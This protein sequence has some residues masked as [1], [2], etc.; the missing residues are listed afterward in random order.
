M[1]V[2]ASLM[3]VSEPAMVSLM[4]TAVGVAPKLMVVF[5]AALTPAT[6]PPIAAL[7][8]SSS[9]PVTAAVPVSVTV[10]GLETGEVLW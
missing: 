6:D 3:M 10:L 1:L 7:F 5:P 2:Y 8:T 9:V 4:Y